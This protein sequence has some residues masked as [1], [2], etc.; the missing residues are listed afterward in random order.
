M[1]WSDQAEQL[2]AV[3]RIMDPSYLANDFFVNAAAEFGPRFYYSHTLALLANFV[4][5][6][7]V[8]A[9]LWLS[10]FVGVAVVTAF[11]ARE[12]SGSVL[13]GMVAVVLITLPEPFDLGSSASYCTTR[14]WCPEPS[15]CLLRCLRSG[16]ESGA[17]LLERQSPRFRPF[18]SSL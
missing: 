3:F 1:D 11:M 10:A 5:L 15:L 7:A 14:F 8:V 12:L 6:P 2:P 18:C 13:G 4:P 17:N 9:V 16:R